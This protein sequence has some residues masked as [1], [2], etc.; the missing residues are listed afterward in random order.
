MAD[1]PDQAI[2]GMEGNLALPRSNGELVFNAPWEGRAFGM[3]VA[4]KDGGLYPWD[5]FRDRLIGQVAQAD[6]PEG[7]LHYYEQW[8]AALVN[9]VTDSGWISE[10]ELDQRTRDYATGQRADGE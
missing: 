10:D 6:G 3:A 7:D 8:L 5:A 2:S 9:L 1:R 4:L